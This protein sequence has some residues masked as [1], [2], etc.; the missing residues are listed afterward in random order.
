MDLTSPDQI[1]KWTNTDP[2]SL[3]TESQAQG[4]SVQAALNKRQRYDYVWPTS[5]ERS[6]QTGMAQGSRGYQADTRTEYIYDNSVWRLTIPYAKFDFSGGTITTSTWTYLPLV[7]VN[8][9]ESTDTTF[10]TYTS[11]GKMV[12]ANPGLYSVSIY[13]RYSST[14]GSWGVNSLRFIDL[15]AGNVAAGDIP[16]QI[17]RGANIGQDNTI[18]FAMP[19]LRVV[20]ANQTYTIDFFQS[21]GVT[22]TIAGGAMHWTRL[23]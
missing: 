22:Q 15:H 3:V 19:N 10:V 2:A 13:L 18:P 5:A 11:A 6:A 23:G 20:A 17:M 8:V 7:S 4:D 21:S 1:V 9:S 14:G 12:V 16:S